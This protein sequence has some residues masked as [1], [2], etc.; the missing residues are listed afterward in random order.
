MKYHVIGK[1]VGE[2]NLVPHLQGYIEFKK[3][4]R[5][6]VVKSFLGERCH[7]EVRKGTRR[8]AAEYCK[9]QGQFWETGSIA[10]QGKRTDLEAIRQS[11][12]SG[13]GVEPVIPRTNCQTLRYAQNV[14]QYL[15]PGRTW[16]TQVSWYWGA[17]GTGKTRTA[18]SELSTNE[19]SRLWVSAGTLQW[20]DG[21]DAHEHVLID[22]FRGDFCKFHTLLRILDRYPFRVPIKGGFRQLLA[23]R[24]IVTAP[25]PPEDMYA[26]RTTEDVAQLL[27]RI[28]EVKQFQ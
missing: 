8:Q 19:D 15:E 14:A 25:L 24:I 22:D 18:Y 20:W 28:D 26:G 9:K 4:L 7:I 6:S 3:A 5:F 17:T 13:E 10:G 16:K 12:K 2:E 23:K 1:E 21:Y 27:R 11:L